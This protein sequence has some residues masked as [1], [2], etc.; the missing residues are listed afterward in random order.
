MADAVEVIDGQLE[1]LFAAWNVW[2]TL[3]ILLLV[4]VAIS[5]LI[6]SKDP[7]THPLLLSRQSNVSLVRQPNE[8]AVFRSLEIPHGLPLRSGLNVKEVGA[9]KWSAGTDGD[10][11]DVWLRAVNGITDSN[12]Q[13]TGRKPSFRSVHGKEIEDHDLTDLTG[14]INIIGSYLKEKG[15]TCVAIYLPNSVEML[16]AVFGEAVSQVPFLAGPS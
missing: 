9:S 4:F 2:T 12:G 16:L 15:S 8:S 13:P 3:L 11:R 6:L 10:L 5:P 14:Q 7:D 1:A